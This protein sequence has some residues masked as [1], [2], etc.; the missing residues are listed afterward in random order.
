MPLVQ[1]V[2][3]VVCCLCGEGGAPVPS[4]RLNDRQMRWSWWGDGGIS[5]SSLSLLF[6]QIMYLNSAFFIKASWIEIKNKA[7]A[8]RRKKGAG[9]NVGLGTRWVSSTARREEI[10]KCLRVAIATPEQKGNS[11]QG[12]FGKRPIEFAS[13]SCQTSPSWS[14]FISDCETSIIGT[15]KKCREWLDSK[16]LWMI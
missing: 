16:V 11:R 10:T 2:P 3:S 13:F 7:N 12:K 15:E 5:E 4:R 1:C 14:V 8:K 9:E 6:P